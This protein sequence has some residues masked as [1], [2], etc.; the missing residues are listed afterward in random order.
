MKKTARQVEVL[1]VSRMD[2]PGQVCAA[3]V[4]GIVNR[5]G[6]ML[7]LDWGIY[8]DERARRTNEVFLPE[9][10]W[11]TKYRN[12]IKRQDLENLAYYKKKYGFRINRISKIDAV[13]KSHG[14]LFRG[15]VV[16]DPEFPDS[17]NVALMLAS[18]AGLLV[19]TPDRIDWARRLG[20]S[21][22]EDLRGRWTD[23]VECY[24]WAFERFFTRCAPG[25]IAC[26]EPGWNR[27]EFLDYAVQNEIFIYSLA[28][29]GEGTLYSIGQKLLLL[30]IAGPIGMR[31][32]IF[33]LRLD[34]AMRALA[35]FLMGARSP[36]LRLGTKLQR[37]VKANPFP[38]IFGWHT[39][40]DDEFCFMAHLSANGLR[41]VPSHLAS[42]FSFHSKLPPRSLLS[43]P[44]ASPER[45]KLERDRIYLSFTLSDG[46]QLVLNNTAQLGN[47]R[48]R[49][50]GGVPFN[51]E[52]QPLLAEIAPALLEFYFETMSRNDYLLAGPSGAGYVIP[53]I[54]KDLKK[55]LAVSTD[56][57]ARAGIRTA[58]S[59]IGDPPMR[60]V[61]EHAAA[62]GGFLGYLA[63]Y[64]HFG[65][66]PVH[67]V[68]GMPF[69]ANRTPHLDHIADGSE[70]TLAEV[71][72]VL[73]SIERPPAFVGVH[74]FAYRTT[75]T[76][77]YRFVKTLDPKRIK[78]VKADEFLIAAGKYLQND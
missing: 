9:D 57:C 12:F 20:F 21:V 13:I 78:V 30:L 25:R 68:R 19:I 15:A 75:I 56:A 7:L 54:L 27:P 59:Y 47:W 66:T 55:Y 23:R 29:R 32:L 70:E 52:T 18:T 53:P 11:R 62:R 67:C 65:R 58:T 43:Q 69:I 24:A 17:V 22:I 26:I 34:G 1:D 71:R 28:A 6:P 33:N 64:L 63:G 50:R 31:N 49:E 74:L 2:Y 73:R 44:H 42:N 46:D 41:L 60:V 40:R 45:V 77:V 3:A 16:W 48:R 4:Q 72:R 8:D 38:T 10:V 35:V 37:A 5:G 14:G 61:R 36:E 51:W 39:R 76:D